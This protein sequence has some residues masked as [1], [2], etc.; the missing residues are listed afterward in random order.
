MS[1]YLKGNYK[2]DP[3][4]G[5]K[6]ETGESKGKNLEDVFESQAFQKLGGSIAFIKKS[7]KFVWSGKKRDDARAKT[8]E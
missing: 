6:S 2:L 5:R 7:T 4:A 1:K 8:G 3:K